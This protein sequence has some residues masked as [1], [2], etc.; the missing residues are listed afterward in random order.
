MK[1]E[2]IGNQQETL[3]KTDLAWLA[4]IIEG[5]GWITMT[6]YKSPKK[7][8]AGGYVITPRIGVCNTDA[9]IIRK[10]RQIFDK[11]GT[12]NYITEHT[13]TRPGSGFGTTMLQVT[14]NRLDTVRNILISIMPYMA[15]QKL[16][17]AELVLD[18][19]SKRLAHKFEPYT[20]GEVNLAGRFM[21]E[22]ISTKGKKRAT[23]LSGF[24]RD[25][26][27]SVPLKTNEKG[28]FL[29]R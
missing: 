24:L 14:T 26:T 19:V 10:A 23:S 12:N 1:D 7:T 28:Q 5:E 4:G 22:C 20:Q 3:K 18:Y 6:A 8:W 27:P 29:A 9:G 21:Q 16:H 17:R 25:F 2:T 13:E 11:L 15:G